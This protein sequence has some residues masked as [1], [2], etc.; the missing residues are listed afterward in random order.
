MVSTVMASGCGTERPLAVGF[1]IDDLAVM[2]DD[3]DGAGHAFLGERQVDG[4]IDRGSAAEGLCGQSGGAESGAPE[5]LHMV[6]L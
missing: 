4:V 2:S 6:L 5:D 1:A 3:Q